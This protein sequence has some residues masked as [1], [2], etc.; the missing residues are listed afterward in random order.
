MNSLNSFSVDAGAGTAIA[1]AERECEAKTGASGAGRTG[2]GTLATGIALG[3]TDGG[4]VIFGLE[5]VELLEREDLWEPL[6]NLRGPAAAC[7]LTTF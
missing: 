3:L 1:G 4:A 7:L 6:A 2:A 5:G